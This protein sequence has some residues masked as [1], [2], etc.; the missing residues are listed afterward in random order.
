MKPISFY[1]RE[2]SKSCKGTPLSQVSYTSRPYL[3]QSPALA[4]YRRKVFLRMIEYYEGVM[5]LTTN[6][7]Q[8]FDRTFQ[9]KPHVAIH[10]PQLAFVSRRA[11]WR[12][13]IVRGCDGFTLDWLSDQKLDHSAKVEL[14]GRQI[15]NVVKTAHAIAKTSGPPLE[16]VHTQSSLMYIRTFD[17]GSLSESDKDTDSGGRLSSAQSAGLEMPAKRPCAEEQI[18]SRRCT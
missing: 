11:L 8:D 7:V 5:L 14:N 13:S 6:Q 15:K 10:D 3:C 12:A 1:N 17:G 2:P 9:S 4:D 18:R 16:T